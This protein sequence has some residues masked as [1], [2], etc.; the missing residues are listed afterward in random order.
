MLKKGNIVDFYQNYQEEKDY[1]GAGLLLGKIKR[2]PAFL[3]DSS[4]I[5]ENEHQLSD[6]NIYNIQEKL[7]YYFYNKCKYVLDDIVSKAKVNITKSSTLELFCKDILMLYSSDKET[8]EILKSLIINTK[9]KVVALETLH[10]LKNNTDVELLALRKL[11][12][13]F[14]NVPV[15]FIVKYVIHVLSKIMKHRNEFD[16]TFD[17]LFGVTKWRV[18]MLRDNKGYELSKKYITN[19]NKREYARYI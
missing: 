17:Y 18:L 11:K 10:K 16:K 9:N 3:V 19:L 14:S 7:K 5:C 2:E 12:I 13:L 15:E 8:P 1:I 4:I 6:D